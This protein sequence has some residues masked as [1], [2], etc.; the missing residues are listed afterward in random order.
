MKEMIKITMGTFGR[1]KMVL[2]PKPLCSLMD[3]DFRVDAASGEDDENALVCFPNLI[4]MKKIS[5]SLASRIALARA[6]TNPGMPIPSSVASTT[7]TTTDTASTNTD[8]CTP[9]TTNSDE[10]DS[11]YDAS[12][13]DFSSIVEVGRTAPPPTNNNSNN[14][15]DAFY[16]ASDEFVGSSLWYD[17]EDNND[18]NDNDDDGYFWSDKDGADPAASLYV[19]QDLRAAVV[20]SGGENLVGDEVAHDHSPVVS[21]GHENQ[22]P[23][24]RPRR[25]C[26]YSYFCLCLCSCSTKRRVCKRH[27]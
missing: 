8:A 24:A 19:D 17:Q 6:A 25:R 3:I 9:V 20:S 14:D 5:L 4:V 16:Y 13:E 22:R 7:T 23:I 26:D 15:Q 2:I 11:F 12:D 27:W 18:D 21:S 1:T 10:V